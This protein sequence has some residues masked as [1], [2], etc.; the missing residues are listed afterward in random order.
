MLSGRSVNDLEAGPRT[1]CLVLLGF[2]FIKLHV[3]KDSSSEQAVCMIL[4]PPRAMT[5]VR[6]TSSI[7]LTI[8][9]DVA[10]PLIMP[11]T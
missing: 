9:T 2:M 5:S 1:I 7:N 10:R 11:K 6:V 4:T 3:E 8:C